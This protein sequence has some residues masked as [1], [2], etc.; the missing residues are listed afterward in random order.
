MAFMHSQDLGMETNQCHKLHSNIRHGRLCKSIV[1][2]IG[3]Y[4]LSD[5]VRTS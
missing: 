2:T 1:L 3:E 4:A 5:E